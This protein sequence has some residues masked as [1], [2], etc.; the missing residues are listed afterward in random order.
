MMLFACEADQVC[1]DCAVFRTCHS[2]EHNRKD[3]RKK[4]KRTGKCPEF[5][6]VN[7]EGRRK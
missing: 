2:K 4:L 6:S 5:K 7:K 1:K 3:L